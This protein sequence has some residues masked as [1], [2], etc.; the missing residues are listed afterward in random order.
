MKDFQIKPF[1]TNVTFGDPDQ[2]VF[3]GKI[4]AARITKYTVR[5]EVTYWKDDD[6]KTIWLLEEDFKVV[7]KFKHASIGFRVED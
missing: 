5:Y 2:K 6:R 1:D 4:T 7:D 3:K